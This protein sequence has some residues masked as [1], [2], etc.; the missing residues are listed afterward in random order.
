MSYI[1]KLTDQ[2]ATHIACCL[3]ILIFHVDI[4]VFKLFFSIFALYLK[5]NV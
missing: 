4:C 5:N 3:L 1:R 2:P